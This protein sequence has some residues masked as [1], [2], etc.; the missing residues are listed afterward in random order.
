MKKRTLI[1]AI[2]SV[3]MLAYLVLA[4]SLADTMRAD[5]RCSGMVIDIVDS[6]SCRFVTRAGI[7]Q[8]LGGIQAKASSMR[9]RDINTDAIERKLDLIDDIEESVCTQLSDGTV[10]LR[11]TP[12]RPV[13]RVY[14]HMGGTSYYIN[15]AGKKMKASLRYRMDVPIIVN[16]GYPSFNAVSLLPM[17]NT[18]HNDSLWN[19]LITT[20]KVTRGGD[21]IL[22][23]SIR[24]HVINLGDTAMLADKLD[25]MLTMYRKVL[26]VKGWDAYDTL[27]VKWR[28]QV[29]AS[30]RD[31]HLAADGLAGEEIIDEEGDDEGTMMADSTAVKRTTRLS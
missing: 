9:L 10:L 1:R 6:A 30:R 31:K 2:L 18:I 7:D 20:V 12:M 22:V 29:V 8:E 24:G 14:N 27:S 16:E 26:P 3:A 15:K 4:L 5:A 25:R 28:G 11:V 17:L 19:S 23:P 21:V 13:A